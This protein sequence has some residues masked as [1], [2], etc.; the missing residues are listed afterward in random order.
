MKENIKESEVKIVDE[1]PKRVKKPCG[2]CEEAMKRENKWWEDAEDMHSLMV[3]A[4]LRAI[5]LD[6]NRYQ[7][8]NE[9]IALKQ[10]ESSGNDFITGMFCGIS[11]CVVALIIISR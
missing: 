1:K 2:G 5:Q 3:D 10:V 11:L 6:R 7:L 4:Q 9:P 8:Q